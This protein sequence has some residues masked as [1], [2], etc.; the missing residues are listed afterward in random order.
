M[1]Q[2]QPT[3]GSPVNKMTYVKLVQLGMMRKKLA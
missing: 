1:G 2:E 3:V